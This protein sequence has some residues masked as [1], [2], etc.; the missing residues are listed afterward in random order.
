MQKASGQ[1][2]M[3]RGRW[4][5]TVLNFVCMLG[6]GVAAH[7]NASPGAS[8]W[9]PS[10]PASPSLATSQFA[11]QVLATGDNLRQPFAIV[12]K[13]AALLTVFTG[14]GQLLGSSPVLL[15]RDYGDHS[16]PG[17]GNRAQTRQLRPG[18]A[19]TPAGRFPSAPGHNNT[20]ESVIW[21]DHGLALA[22]HRLRPGATQADRAKRLSAH[23]VS[24]KRVSAG[25]VVVP[26]AFYEWVLQPLLGRQ[27]GVVYVLSEHGQAVGVLQPFAPFAAI[28]AAPF[29]PT[30]R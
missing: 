30:L 20:G 2:L 25:C 14:E 17:V 9:T 29:Q 11:W 27:P 4:F 12:D 6:I 23:D 26:V 10:K 7:S 18:D 19:T 3:R 16:V 24:R 22:L 21:L 13:R 28:A 8:L 1:T 5:W 15:G